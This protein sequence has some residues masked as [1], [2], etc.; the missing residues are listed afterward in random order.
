MATVVE[1]TPLP[2]SLHLSEPVTLVTRGD[3]SLFATDFQ[4]YL[5]GSGS[6]VECVSLTK[7]G[8]LNGKHVSSLLRAYSCG[9]WLST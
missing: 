6:L 3:K 8:P 4:A 1:T 7:L 5:E 2:R 9:V